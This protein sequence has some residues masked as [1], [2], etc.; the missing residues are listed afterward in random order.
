MSI[1]AICIGILIDVIFGGI[2]WF[3]LAGSGSSLL[4]GNV[5]YTNYSIGEKISLENI[6]IT[7]I[8][9]DKAKQINNNQGQAIPLETA[10]YFLSVKMTIENHDIGTITWNGDPFSVVDSSGRT[11]SASSKAE[12]YYPNAVT[13][14][15]IQLQPGIPFNA[16]KIFEIPE[17]STGLKLNMVFSKSQGGKIGAHVGLGK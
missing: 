12:V 5:N 15:G 16:I 13:K 17:D 14:A 6:S 10:G 11:F 1:L 9:A 3:F 8:S 4:P 7:V 2:L